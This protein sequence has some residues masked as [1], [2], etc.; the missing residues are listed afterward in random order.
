MNVPFVFFKR[1]KSEILLI[2][3]IGSGPEN[4]SEIT[5]IEFE[6][7][8]IVFSNENLAIALNLGQTLQRYK[9]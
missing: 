4:S 3:S 8:D 1:R 2:S 6:H 9:N 7:L 5:V